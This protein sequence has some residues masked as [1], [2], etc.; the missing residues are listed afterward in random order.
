LFLVSS[1]ALLIDCR[2]SSSF[3]YVDRANPYFIDR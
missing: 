1:I 3:L 2:C